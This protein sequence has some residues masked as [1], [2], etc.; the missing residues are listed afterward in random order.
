MKQK[1]KKPKLPKSAPKER[2]VYSFDPPRPHKE[3]FGDSILPILGIA[4]IIIAGVFIGGYIHS[5]TEILYD[6]QEL[7][8]KEISVDEMK[9]RLL[10]LC[11]ALDK[12]AEVAEKKS[13]ALHAK[14]LCIVD[15]G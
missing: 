9:N 11:L 4:A 15:K 1:K 8:A 14:L 3:G 7:P 2:I 12:N 6:K 10:D 5:K 13:G